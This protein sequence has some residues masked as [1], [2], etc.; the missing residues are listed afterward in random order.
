[1]IATGSGDRTARTWDAATGAERA[2]LRGHAGQ[3]KAVSFAPD[4]SLL[5]T[6]S[7][8][9]T[10]CVWDPLSGAHVRTL[11]GH[12]SWV[13]G[14]AFS[15][16]GDLI[17]T[18][19]WDQTTRIWDAATG[20]CLATLAGHAGTVEAVAFSPSGAL[21]ATASSDATARLWD[22]ASGAHLA[23]LVPLPSGGYLTLLPDARYKLDG[24]PGDCLW[25][26]AGL[27]RLGPAEVSSRFPEVRRA[28]PAP[29]SSQLEPFISLSTAGS[30]LAGIGDKPGVRFRWREPSWPCGGVIGDHAA[31]AGIAQLRIGQISAKKYGP[32]QVGSGQVRSAEVST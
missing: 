13:Y 20:A 10:A 19:S 7:D 3:V 1:M 6:A 12:D 5:A 17:A 24:D 18:A 14:V 16:R 31:E 27:C 21:L 22:A 25:W 11:S 2:T 15:P 29:R 26:A 4:G 28:P 23:T 8:D 9:R 30:H 32:V